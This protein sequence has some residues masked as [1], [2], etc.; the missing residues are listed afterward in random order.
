MIV[1]NRI[2]IVENFGAGEV[3][4]REDRKMT[5]EEKEE[6]ITGAE[7]F[8]V[9]TL[10][11]A[12]GSGGDPE[13]PSS[14]KN[15]AQS[16]AD[17]KKSQNSHK[18]TNPFDNANNNN[19]WASH[20]NRTQLFNWGQLLADETSDFNFGKYGLSENFLSEKGIEPL[21]F[22][23]LDEPLKIDILKQYLT[24]QELRIFD[25]FSTISQQ[26]A[27]NNLHTQTEPEVVPIAQQVTELGL[28][29]NSGE[30]LDCLVDLFT[31]HS[32]D[33]LP[34]ILELIDQMKSMETSVGQILKDLLFY[35]ID[36]TVITDELEKVYPGVVEH[37]EMMPDEDNDGLMLED[38]Q[39]GEGP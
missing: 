10:M 20:S 22:N 7:E 3:Q 39:Q 9:E 24:D 38:L 14:E 8:Q 17:E 36:K 21:F 4:K 5:E 12:G 27:T 18:N 37:Y 25:E 6:M 16:A 30:I 34:S 28:E 31:L 13:D 19:S 35:E 11:V 15:S 2:G 33:R 23:V 32:L 26:P 1:E 29:Y